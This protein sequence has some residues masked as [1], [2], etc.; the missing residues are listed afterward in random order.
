MKDVPDQR[1]I[2]LEIPGPR[3]FRFL[4]HILNTHLVFEREKQL[5]T[6]DGH[7]GFYY[8]L[9]GS[10]PSH[11]GK[12]VKKFSDVDVDLTPIPLLDIPP[13]Y[14]CPLSPF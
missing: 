7:S 2:H 1:Y 3:P 4:Q 8:I 14:I 9:T 12:S 13:L 6:R 5:M 11:L 10:Y